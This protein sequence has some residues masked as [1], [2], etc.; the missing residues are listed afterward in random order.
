MAGETI[1]SL[2]AGVLTT[3]PD[4]T[5]GS[6]TVSILAD[7]LRTVIGVG[8]NFTTLYKGNKRRHWIHILN[9]TEAYKILSVDSATQLTLVSDGV[10]VAP[11]TWTAIEGNLKAYGFSL[12]SGADGIVNGVLVPAGQSVAFSETRDNYWCDVPVLLNGVTTTRT[13]ITEKSEPN[14]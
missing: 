8:T 7:G 2:P 10:A 3:I 4:G 6:G 1:R 5:A 14:E 12:G 13:I 9:H 11:A